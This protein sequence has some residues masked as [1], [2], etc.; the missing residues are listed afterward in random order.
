MDD[1]GFCEGKGEREDSNKGRTMRLGWA[2]MDEKN[3]WYVSGWTSGEQE[4]AL[5]GGLLS[6]EAFVREGVGGSR[7]DWSVSGDGVRE[8]GFEG[9]GVLPAEDGGVSRRGRKANFGLALSACI[10]DGRRCAKWGGGL[11]AD[12]G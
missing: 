8:G 1:R 2:E 5:D 10:L 7:E 12:V 3:G 4:E 9:Y 6:R 11:Y